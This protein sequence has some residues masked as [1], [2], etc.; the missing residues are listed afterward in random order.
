MNGEQIYPAS[1]KSRKE[2]LKLPFINKS[3]LAKHDLYDSSST[4]APESRK[5]MVQNNRVINEKLPQDT[6]MSK[7]NS[8]KKLVENKEN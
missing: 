7:R 5:A 2:D 4:S 1:T 6:F 3:Q 8:V